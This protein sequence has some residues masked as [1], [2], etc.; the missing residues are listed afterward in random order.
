[1][2]QILVDIVKLFAQ[3][4]LGTLKNH[5]GKILFSLSCAIFFLLIIFPYSDLTSFASDKIYQQTK[6]ATRIEAM[7]ISLLP[8][9]GALLNGVQINISSPPLKIESVQV[10]PSPLSSLV[11]RDAYFTADLTG[12]LGG[13][14]SMTRSPGGSVEKGDHIKENFELKADNIIVEKLLTLLKSNTLSPMN[15]PVNLRGKVSIESDGEIDPKFTEQPEINFVGSGTNIEFPRQTL[16][17]MM[18]PLVIEAMKWK[19]MSLKGRMIA[20]EIIIEELLLGEKTDPLFLKLKGKLSLPLKAGSRGLGPIRFGSY[21]LDTDLTLTRGANS[22]LTMMMDPLAGSFKTES[23]QGTRYVFRAS[24][25][26]FGRPP[27]TQSIR[28]F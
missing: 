11:H 19:S 20:G 1:M 3:F 7:G 2:L 10:S 12:A 14:L 18:G 4:L 25:S 21:E 5:W 23:R 28:P 17:T 8:L 24:G 15:V 6:I 16:N 22:L 9:P 13:E 26:G 27:R